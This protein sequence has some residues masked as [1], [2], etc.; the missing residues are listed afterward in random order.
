MAKNGEA[1]WS[2]YATIIAAVIGAVAL[3]GAAWISQKRS[4]IADKED[5]SHLICKTEDGQIGKV[6]AVPAT[7]TRSAYLDC[8][9]K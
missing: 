3:L 8:V 6:Q 2:A 9:A 4:L 5:D 7:E 1:R